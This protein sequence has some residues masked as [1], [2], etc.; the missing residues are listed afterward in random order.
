MGAF[1][2][3]RL[4]K[5]S[6]MA[7]GY[8]HT[9][10][11]CMPRQILTKDVWKRAVLRTDVLSPKITPKPHFGGHFN[12]KPVIQW[13]LCK[14]HVNGALKLKLYSY[15]G[16]GKYLG[17]CQNFSARGRPG[18]AGPLNVNLEPRIISET[19]TAR[20]LKLKIQLDVVK[21]LLWVQKFFR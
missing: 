8:T 9:E 10:C 4:P 17:V 3:R 13:A 2:H 5:F 20:K 6:P 12:A 11:Y 19:S 21:Y 15:I 14:S 1:W 7:N 16:I 18:G